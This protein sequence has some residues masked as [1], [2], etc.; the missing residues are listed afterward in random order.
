MFGFFKKAF[1]VM[2]D[3][4]LSESEIERRDH[5]IELR[6]HYAYQRELYEMY[7]KD[8]VAPLGS[9]LHN[10][11]NKAGV[12]PLDSTLENY[13]NLL[14]AVHNSYEIQKRWFD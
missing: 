2:G 9:G 1:G 13:A 5:Y 12:T 11:K 10:M 7:R 3:I 6:N 14:A 4:V 8:G